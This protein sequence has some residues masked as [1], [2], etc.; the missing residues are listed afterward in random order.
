MT[1]NVLVVA[2]FQEAWVERLQ[3]LSAD[4]HVTLH[5]IRGRGD[6]VPDALWQE[7]E[8]AYTY[9]NHL[10]SPE[11]ASHLRW[12]QLYSAGAEQLLEK[13]LFNQDVMFTTMSGIHA[14]PIGEY[15]LTT[16]LAWFH[17]LPLL[18]DWQ[19]QQVWQRNSEL[20]AEFMPQEVRGKTIG[21]VG[22]GSIGR[23]V[24]RLAKAF[25]MRVVAM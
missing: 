19:R 18:L 24:A 22:Y 13:P 21:I 10:P 11:Q 15:V 23:E 7:T 6:R 9:S 3:G 25:G 12:A 5:P 14:T 16:M 2:R 17:R 4:V 20:N 1:V 8:V